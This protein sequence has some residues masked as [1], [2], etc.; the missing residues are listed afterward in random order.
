MAKVLA[1]HRDDAEPYYTI[2]LGGRSRSTERTKLVALD[3]H[4]RKYPG[5]LEDS[6]GSALAGAVAAAVLGSAR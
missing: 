3:A 6:G 4:C 2:E 5:F 1:V